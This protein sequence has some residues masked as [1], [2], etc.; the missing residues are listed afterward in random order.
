LYVPAT[1]FPEITRP[2]QK[3]RGEEIIPA[4][5]V[6]AGI[7]N[8][9]IC[10]EQ[11][12]RPMEPEKRHACCMSAAMSD[13]NSTGKQVEIG[14]LIHSENARRLPRGLAKTYG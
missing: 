6:K 13:H 12:S 7:R 8:F 9:A 2:V 1:R 5:L 14:W 4:K 3:E 11:M 10:A